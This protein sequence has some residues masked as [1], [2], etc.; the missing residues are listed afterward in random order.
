MLAFGRADAAAPAGK[1]DMNPQREPHFRRESAGCAA[2]PTAAAPALLKMNRAH[3][4]AQ[5]QLSSPQ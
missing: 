3:P 4:A 1:P 5:A 2:E